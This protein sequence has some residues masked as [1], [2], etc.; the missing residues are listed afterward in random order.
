MIA[1]ASAAML[2]HRAED[3]SIHLRGV[4]SVAQSRNVRVANESRVHVT[5][6]S[7]IF[8]GARHFEIEHAHAESLLTLISPAV[9]RTHHDAG[10][11]F[12]LASKVDHGVRDR[13]IALNR[14]STGPEE[15]VARF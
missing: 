8:V 2:Q 10:T 9:T 15:Q 4:V 5:I 12:L 1:A 11:G 7:L 14:I 13:W 6:F 3:C